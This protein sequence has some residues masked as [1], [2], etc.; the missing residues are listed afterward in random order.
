MDLRG[1]HQAGQMSEAEQATLSVLQ[2]RAENA[3]VICIVRPLSDP[4]A[5]S[6]I[7]VLDRASPRFLR[8]LASEQSVQQGRQLTT[9]QTPRPLVPVQFPGEQNAPPSENLRNPRP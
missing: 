8:E 4:R 7:I 5:K 2:Q 6:E 3:E 9:M 1:S